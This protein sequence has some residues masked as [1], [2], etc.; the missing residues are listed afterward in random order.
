MRIAVR[1]LAIS[2]ALGAGCNRAPGVGL[3]ITLPTEAVAETVWFEVG[4]FK[5]AKCASVSP[6]LADGVPDGWTGR[7]AFRRD[8]KSAP[9]FGEIPNARYAFGAV[10]RSETCGVVASGCSEVDF[11]KSDAVKI[12]MAVND[13]A[14]GECTIGAICEAARCVPANDNEDPT[15][16]A[17][18]SLELLGAG[19]LATSNREDVRIMSAPAIAATATTV[20]STS[21][22]VVYREGN[23]ASSILTLLPVDSGGGALTPEQP[24]LSGR[25]G[26]PEEEDGIGLFV[27]DLDAV[28]TFSRP[29]CLG[30]PALEALTLT[31]NSDIDPSRPTIGELYASTSPASDVIALSPSRA[32]AARP[33]GG[34]LVVFTQAGAGRIATITKG[35]GVTDPS[36]T[37]GGTTGITGAWIAATDKVVALLSAGDGEADGDAGAA[38]T[39]R[40]LR[41][42]MAPPDSTAATFDLATNKPHAPIVF[43]G[44]WGSIAAVGDRVIVLTD[45]AGR[46]ESVSF[47]AFDVDDSA[48]VDTNGFAI[49]GTNPVTAGDVVIVGDR[50]YF[51]AL[52][53]GAIEL[54]VYSNATKTPTPLARRSLG[55]EGRISGIRNIRDGRVA[56]AATETRVAVAWTTARELSPNDPPGGYAVFGCSK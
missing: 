16:G 56:V 35:K 28:A 20:T 9:R 11:G 23:S 27:S 50:V 36:G 55:R 32:A 46:G 4:A 10:A 37:F 24:R 49:D 1:A 22:L 54:H 2:I 40:A 17:G 47:R 33:G 19:P 34:G 53:Q 31:T 38:P 39:D 8:A 26:S 14:T 44:T 25:C 15:V 51:A 41:L 30:K 43:P 3:E 6:M 48:P 12:D 45:D 18:C 52:A 7:V 21:F 42:L 13:P 5:D 29:P